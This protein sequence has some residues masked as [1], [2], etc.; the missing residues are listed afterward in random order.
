MWNN[1]CT[2]VRNAGE[3]SIDGLEIE[4]TFRATE[5][6]TLEQLLVYLILVMISLNMMDKM[7]QLRHNLNFA[8]DYTA[9]LSWEYVTEFR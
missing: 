2:F 7:L 9:S 8:P 1:R 5:A 4:G 3:V 6:L